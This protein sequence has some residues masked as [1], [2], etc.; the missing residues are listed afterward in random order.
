MS[1]TRE[2]KIFCFNSSLERKSFKT[3]QALFRRMF[4]LNN[5]PRKS[6]IYHW[7]H[8]FQATSF[9][10]N[11]NKKAENFRSGRKPT[12][13]CPENVDAVRDSVGRSPKKSYRR[14]SKELGLSR[15]L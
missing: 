3:E 13:R 2:E 11:L 8:K 9:V 4:N 14:R 15:A 6:Q 7:I 12:A 5:Y 10:N 1:L